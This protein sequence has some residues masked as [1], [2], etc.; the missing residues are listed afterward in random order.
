M[1]VRLL[2]FRSTVRYMLSENGIVREGN[3]R[4]V[5]VCIRSS[6]P[7]PKFDV[8]ASANRLFQ[9]FWLVVLKTM[10]QELR[11]VSQIA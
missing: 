9:N 6:K 1:G 8:T 4:P 10:I 5:C 3:A 7:P 2:L 11:Y